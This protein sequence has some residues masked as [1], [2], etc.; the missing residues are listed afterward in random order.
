M[1]AVILYVNT[2]KTRISVDCFH[3]H[4]LKV[5]NHGDTLKIIAT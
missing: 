1:Y 4:H 5:S 2:N 3:C